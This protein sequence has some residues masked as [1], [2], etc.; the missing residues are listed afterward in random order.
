MCLPLLHRRCFLNEP[1]S[2]P[3]SVLGRSLI[4]L[5]HRG[6][7]YLIRNVPGN[8]KQ[9]AQAAQLSACSADRTLDR[10]RVCTSRYPN[11]SRDLHLVA[12]RHR[13]ARIVMVD[14][15]RE[16]G[17][18]G[19]QRHRPDLHR[20]FKS[21][22]MTEHSRRLCQQGRPF[23]VRRFRSSALARLLH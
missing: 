7:R 22:R 20:A 18:R 10:R 8:S 9:P 13:V 17:V 16:V 4:V 1:H 6:N 14:K 5:R 11:G 3:V 19:A 12:R 21:G 23:E 15:I 2:W